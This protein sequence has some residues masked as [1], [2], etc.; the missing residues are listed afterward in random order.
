MAERDVANTNQDLADG[1]GRAIGEGALYGLGMTT[2][3]GIPSTV[4]AGAES[5]A[6]RAGQ[7]FNDRVAGLREANEKPRQLLTRLFFKLPLRPKPL[8]RRL[9]LYCVKQLL[10]LL[11]NSKLRPMPMWIA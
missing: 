9:K 2:A 11:L 8:H 10:L 3:L 6:E 7:A 1:V 5:V 4:R